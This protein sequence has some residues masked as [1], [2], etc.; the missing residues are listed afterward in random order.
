MKSSHGNSKKDI[1]PYKRTH[2]EVLQHAANELKTKKPRQVYKEI[3]LNDE[4]NAPRDLQLR[5]LKYRNKEKS[6]TTKGNNAADDILNVI[7]M[8]KDHQFIQKLEH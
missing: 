8:V 1:G 7:L 2:P 6:A 3:I 5:D 4:A